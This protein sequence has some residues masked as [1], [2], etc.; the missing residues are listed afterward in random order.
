M[1]AL[2]NFNFSARWVNGSDDVADI[3]LQAGEE[4]IS[5]I[6]DADTQRERT[7][8]R[9]SATSVALWLADNWWRLRWE[10][11][12]D[13]VG[14]S[15][16]SAS[17]RLRHELNSANGGAMWPPAMIYS[18]GNR[19]AIAP[20]TAR[21]LVDGPQRYIPFQ[22]GMIAANEYEAELDDF[23]QSVIG[24]CARTLDGNALK[25]LI[26]Q[27]LTERS[28]PELAAWRRL[29]ACLGFDA[30]EAPDAVINSLID[31]ESVAGEEGVE[32]A[33]HAQPGE[34]SA[35]SLEK[36]INATLQSELKV[37]LSLAKELRETLETCANKT[38]WQMAEEA[39]THLRSI[40]GVKM[41]QFKNDS[42]AEIFKTRWADLKSASAT[43]RELKY[44]A[45]IGE[46]HSARISLQFPSEIDRRF[47]LAR[48]FGDAIWANNSQF[49]IVSRSKTDRQKFQRAFANNLLCPVD[50]MQDIVDDAEN[51]LAREE[52]GKRLKVR[53][54]IV[55]NQLVYAG[56]LPFRNINQRAEAA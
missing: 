18:V 14:F 22:M 20:S 47:E 25:E 46:E 37:D 23:F 6:E 41:G 52:A 26:G 7:F 28:D 36:V 1:K 21:R 4:I 30:D 38:P 40:I 39:A 24:H 33:A 42:L 9:A 49:G 29:E 53:P 31:L 35:E 12:P 3:S 17:W 10:T 50:A 27:I 45:R 34:N 43:A 11:Y 2:K 44:A 55:H 56:Y 54:S 51:Q 19:I 15:R 13:L 5:K 32:E 16:P 48:Q 8:F